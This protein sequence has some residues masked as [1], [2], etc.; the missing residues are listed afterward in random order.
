MSRLR[1][2]ASFAHVAELRESA[3]QGVVVTLWLFAAV[4][5]LRWLSGGFTPPDTLAFSMIVTPVAMISGICAWWW[6][7]VA[8]GLVSTDGLTKSKKDFTFSF[9]IGKSRVQSLIFLL[10]AYF[11]GWMLLPMHSVAGGMLLT[12]IT[13]IA[14]CGMNWTHEALKISVDLTELT[15]QTDQEF[16]QIIAPETSPAHT[17]VDLGSMFQQIAD[18]KQNSGTEVGGRSDCETIDPELRERVTLWMTRE[19]DDDGHDLLEGGTKVRFLPGQK[20]AVVHL[21]FFPSF[22]LIP[23][24]E[25][26][27][28]DEGT[29]HIRPAAVYSYGARLEIQRSAP[30]DKSEVVDLGFTVRAPLSRMSSAA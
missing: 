13:V 21:G 2:H 19:S 9:D 24:I 29:F 30:L 4:I 17:V 15:V 8:H 27:V 16:P 10:P 22:S 3:P 12:A 6:N 26:E 18:Q 5:G 28:L 23:E 20:L 11:L 1:I 25:C 14:L 7:S